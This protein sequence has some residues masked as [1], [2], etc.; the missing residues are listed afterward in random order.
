MKE[1][2]DQR[3]LVE[4]LAE[5]FVRRYRGGERP[6]LTEYVEAHPGLAAEIR[7]LL[8]ALV[9]ME[10]LGPGENWEVE[11][12]RPAT[13]AGQV[14]DYRLL[15]EIGRGGMGVVYEAEQLCLGRRVA[16]KV[17]TGRPARDAKALERFRREA[18]AAARLHHTNIVPVFEV[19]QDAGIC[20]Y[21][22]QLIRGQGLDEVLRELRR[23]HG[24]GARA[25][26]EAAGEAHGLARS[27]R[28]A[29]FQPANLGA[30]QDGTGEPE[31]ALPKPSCPEAPST[32]TLPGPS[33]LSTVQT[34]PSHY[35]RAVARIGLQVAE[36]LAHAHARGIIHR[37]VKPSNLLLDTTGVVWVTDF[38]LAKTEG[39][40][41]TEAGDIVGTLRYMSPE[42]FAGRCDARADVYGLGLTLYEL[43]VLRPAFDGPDR[44][45]VIEQIKQAELPRP[46]GLDRYIPRDL[47][48]VV[49]NA[50]DKDPGRRYQSAGDLAED[51]RRFLA[52][53]PILARRPT[54]LHK[55][56]KLARRHRLAVWSVAASAAVLVVLALA[57]LAV[58]NRLLTEEQRQTREARAAE[59][60]LAYFRQVAL[61]HRELEGDNVGRAEEL[62][63][64]CPEELRGWEW[65]YLKRLRYGS[66]PPLQGHGDGV[67]DVAFSP[68]GRLLATPG[69]DGTFR[70]WDVASRK[71]VRK[72][73][74]DPKPVF[75][76]A[77]HP[78][79]GLL[80]AGAQGEI[81]VWDVKQGRLVQRYHAH[82]RNIWTV[83][84]RPD[85]RQLATA[86]ADGTVK[87]WDAE[88]WQL[89]RQLDH[90]DGACGVAYSPDG[91]F[92]ATG[93]WEH[94]S[95]FDAATGQRL[96]TL[97]GHYGT[98]R[99]AFH[100]DSSM[101][102]SSGHDG[103]IRLWAA[104]TGEPLGTIRGQPEFTF[105]LAF[106]P[107]SGTRLAAGGWDGVVRIWDVA[108]RQEILALRGHRHNVMGLAFSPGGDLLASASHDMTVRLWDATPLDG[109]PAGEMFTLRKH[110]DKVRDLAYSPDGRL[111]ASASYDRSVMLWDAETGAHL[112][113][114]TGHTDR[115]FSAAFSPDGR[116]LASGSGYYKSGEVKVWDVSQ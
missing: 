52:D 27:L 22:M 94:V 11:A 75:S 72:L 66:P 81:T 91:R 78:Q 26:E 33:D 54:L 50:T 7:E 112:R 84:F 82:D 38:G 77:F 87:V 25:V 46:R 73:Q 3:E 99:L 70:L 41:L 51:L 29:R 108:T 97:P 4:K 88:T 105:T 21:A 76:V 32:A 86:S 61:A 49:L 65:R 71:E 79:G 114:L 14:G 28:T 116:R 9:V 74:G 42:R 90:P 83:A 17:L 96:H 45:Q 55:V 53:L 8:P 63:A 57:G 48:T 18:R 31:L 13:A 104:A 59:R 110:A 60:Q 101:L 40:A 20:Y 56:H 106:S 68:D 24:A 109:K 64:E 34:A 44:L 100:P 92:L 113:T 93:S 23:L 115:V 35:F 12:G 95:L 103:D 2:T 47:E 107:G 1:L 36:A 10:E 62:L 5:D 16:L 67:G 69:V 39:H 58:S 15:R 80:V 37:D 102:A 30:S 89:L 98:T 85:G 6:S 19:G 43:L 111:L